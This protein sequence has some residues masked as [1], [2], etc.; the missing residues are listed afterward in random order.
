MHGSLRF[1]PESASVVVTGYLNWFPLFFAFFFALEAFRMDA[2]FFLL[3]GTGLIS[4]I[5]LVQRHYFSQVAEAAEAAW[6]HSIEAHHRVESNEAS[7][8]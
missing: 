3:L 1:L 5:Y 4:F 6:V 2:S 7:A 8:T